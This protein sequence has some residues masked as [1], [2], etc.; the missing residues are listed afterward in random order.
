LPVCLAISFRK[1]ENYNYA[2]KLERKPIHLK[3]GRKGTEP[4]AMLAQ[5]RKPRKETKTC[6]RD[7]HTL[8][9]YPCK[10]VTGNPKT[11][12]SLAYVHTAFSMPPPTEGV[13]NPQG[14]HRRDVTLPKD[15]HYMIILSQQS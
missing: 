14:G 1:L 2:K 13:V 6:Q 10:E 9:E 5:T 15:N 4:C 3:R 12:Q 11:P 8:D 7:K